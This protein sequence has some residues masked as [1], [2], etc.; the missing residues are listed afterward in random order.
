MAYCGGYLRRVHFRK[1]KIN[2]MMVLHQ[3]NFDVKI[4]KMSLT[5]LQDCFCVIEKMGNKLYYLSIMFRL[6]PFRTFRLIHFENRWGLIRKQRVIKFYYIRLFMIFSNEL[7]HIPFKL[8][9]LIIW[10]LKIKLFNRSNWL[11][12]FLYYDIFKLIHHFIKSVLL[13]PWPEEESIRTVTLSNILN[14]II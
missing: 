6:S 5:F 2:F 14:D 10:Q 1:L 13:S 9:Q 8:V 11:L 12:H 4:I 3:D 7:N